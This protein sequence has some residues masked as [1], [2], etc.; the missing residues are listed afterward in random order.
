MV[1]ES[2]TKELSTGQLFER[3]WFLCSHVSSGAEAVFCSEI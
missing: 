3:Q 2:C 1:R